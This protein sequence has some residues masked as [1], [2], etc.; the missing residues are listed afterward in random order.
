MLEGWQ[1]I[2]ASF[3]AE[4]S[5]NYGRLKDGDNSILPRIQECMKFI[6]QTW[7]AV[8]ERQESERFKVCLKH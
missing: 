2:F 6:F 4:E 8:Q 7:N 1:A 3:W 5:E